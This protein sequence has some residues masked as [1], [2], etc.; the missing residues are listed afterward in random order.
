MYSHPTRQNFPSRVSS[1][2]R[3]VNI[4]QPRRQPVVQPQQPIQ[5]RTQNN[6]HIET[7]LNE[8]NQKIIVLEENSKNNIREIQ[9]TVLALE[10][11]IEKLESGYNKISIALSNIIEE[12]E[13][14]ENDI[15]TEETI[16]VNIENDIDTKQEESIDTKQ[17]ESIDN[18]CT[19]DK[20]IKDSSD[21]SDTD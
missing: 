10:N 11:K 8:F 5:N 16:R 14:P 15:K 2:P 9:S 19:K 1:I 18:K 12:L 7:L 4:N 21:L 17:E 6:N 3:F 13:K 20:Y